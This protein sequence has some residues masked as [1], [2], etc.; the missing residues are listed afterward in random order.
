MR[1]SARS[2]LCTLVY[3]RSISGAGVFSEQEVSE[4]EAAYEL[5]AAAWP[6]ATGSLPGPQPVVSRLLDRKRGEQ[7][8]QLRHAEGGVCRPQQSQQSVLLSR[9]D[10][11]G[12]SCTEEACNVC[13]EE[14]EFSGFIGPKPHTRS[15]TDEGSNMGSIW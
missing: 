9:K 6:T 15:G 13:Y 7:R 3:V 14:A 4:G 11:F 8:R 1:H 12:T 10:T 2:V 5:L